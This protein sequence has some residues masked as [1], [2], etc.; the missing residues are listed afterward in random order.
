MHRVVTTSTAPRY[1][2]A[3][4]TY[5]DMGAVIKPLDR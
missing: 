5:P 4:F 3:Y 2:T 1:S